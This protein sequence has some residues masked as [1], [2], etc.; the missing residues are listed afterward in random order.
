MYPNSPEITFDK[1]YYC[2]KHI[3]LISQ[4]LGDAIKD[5]Q[6][7]FGLVGAS[8]EEA[9]AFVAMVFMTFDSVEAFQTAFEPHALR[10]IADIP[11]YTNAQPQIQI[12]EIVNK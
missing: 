8:A 9:P 12:S 2:N 10:L 4:L 6:V 3:T 1:E 7:S 5:I 11:N